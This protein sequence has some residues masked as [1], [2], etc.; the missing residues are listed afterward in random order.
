[1]R[2]ARPLAR[3]NDNDDEDDDADVDGTDEDDHD[4]GN[5]E[6]NNGDSDGDDIG[7]DN[8]V[9]HDTSSRLRRRGVTLRRKQASRDVSPASRPGR[10]ERTA[11][12]PH[13]GTH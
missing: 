3:T 11:A 2:K 6:D 9:G 12:G 10:A 5:D 1:M 13:E 8:D 4:D 7:D